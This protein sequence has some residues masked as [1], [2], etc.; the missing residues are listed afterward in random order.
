[1]KLNELE[2][3]VP[4]ILMGLPSHVA[5]CFSVRNCGKY[6]PSLF[7]NIEDLRAGLPNTRVTCIFVYDNCSDNS[8]QLIREY[9]CDHPDVL[10]DTLVN[11]SP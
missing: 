7:A 2:G 4:F 6:L 5:M 9:A 11:M 10:V 1:M 8:E 3:I